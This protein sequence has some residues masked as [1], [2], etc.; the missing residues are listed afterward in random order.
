V[1]PLQT[2]LIHKVVPPQRK[3]SEKSPALI[4]LHGRGANES[5]LLGLSQY[6]DERLFI[7]AAR[8]P[9][10]FP[11]GGGFTWYEIEEVGIPEPKMFAESYR[12]LDQFFHDVK[13][14][15]P[16]EPSKIFIGGFSMGTV[17]AYAMALTKPQ[18]VAGIVANS[19]YMPEG[20]ALALQ[21]DKVK[22]KPFFVAHGV[23]D[24][25][26]PVQFG[27]R[28]KELLQKASVDLTYREY[29]MGHQIGEESLNDL[30]QW[31]TKHI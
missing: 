30:M 28:A 15:Y 5:D 31:L 23:Y 18:E 27:R 3:T 26:I 12:K 13:K 2:S 4:L 14:H 7:I 11:H 25:V 10:A 16:I 8:A 1:N 17:M 22:G 6:L 21:W 20:T 24:P 9:F 19:G 29:E